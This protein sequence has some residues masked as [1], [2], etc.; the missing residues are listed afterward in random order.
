M[1]G[2]MAMASG[3]TGAM[4][5]RHAGIAVPPRRVKKGSTSNRGMIRK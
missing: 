4:A 3:R 2:R 1:A 5:L